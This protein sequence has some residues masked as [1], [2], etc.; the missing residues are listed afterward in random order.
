MAVLISAQHGHD[1]NGLSLASTARDSPMLARTRTRR[2]IKHLASPWRWLMPYKG[3]RRSGNFMAAR[4]RPTVRL[5]MHSRHP[6]PKPWVRQGR[7]FVGYVVKV[8][9][10]VIFSTT[11]RRFRSPKIGCEA[12]SC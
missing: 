2:L 6:L 3:S 7:P 10:V 11:P 1:V 5:V 12:R 9:G 4:L 8:G